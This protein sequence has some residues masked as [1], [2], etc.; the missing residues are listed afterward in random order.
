MFQFQAQFN[1]FG[2]FI[3]SQLQVVRARAFGIP[4]GGRRQRA[5]AGNQNVIVGNLGAVQ[6]GTQNASPVN[7]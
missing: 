5:R 3:L 7:T 6:T 1:P 2:A 4:F